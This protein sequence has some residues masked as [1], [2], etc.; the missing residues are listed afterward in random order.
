MA[1]Q[2]AAELA[3]ALRV[4]LIVME[5]EDEWPNPLPL[6]PVNPAWAE[7]LQETA[8]KANEIRIQWNL[9]HLEARSG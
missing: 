7:H 9:E 8:R 2:T 5:P 1:E 3:E 4:M 6:F